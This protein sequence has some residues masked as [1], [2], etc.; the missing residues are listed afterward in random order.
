VQNFFSL[1]GPF[2]KYGGML[3]DMIILS[4]MWL[5]FSV[6]GLGI[7]VGA[8]TSALFFVTTRRIANR[9]GYITRDF[10][11]A[12]KANIKKATILWLIVVVL[13]WLIWFNINNIGAV[14]RLSVII[15]PAQIVLLAEIVLMSVYAFPMTAR[16]DMSI[17]HIIKSSFFMANRHLFTSISCVVLLTAAVLSFFIIPPVA[18]FLA[19]GLYGLLASYMIMKI[20]KKYRPEMDKDP[21]M[22]IQEIEAQ[23]A[24][25][26]R[27]RGYSTGQDFW[28]EVDDESVTPERP[29]ELSTEEYTELVESEPEKHTPTPVKPKPKPEDDF[30]SSVEEDSSIEGDNNEN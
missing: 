5:F 9:E 30:W 29:W 27:K 13:A 3:A 6:I 1:D 20:F 7:T 8:S 24:E 10:W 12:F 16:F 2:N 28:T 22:E 25:E 19:P 23:K 15:F 4:F 14:G 21:M 18:L 26:R 17:K 11:E